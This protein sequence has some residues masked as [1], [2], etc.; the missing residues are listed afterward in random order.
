MLKKIVQAVVSLS[1][2]ALSEAEQKR[3]AER[4]VEAYRAEIDRHNWTVKPRDCPSGRTILASDPH[5]QINVLIAICAAHN[6]WELHSLQNSLYARALPWTEADLERLLTHIPQRIYNYYSDN[7][8]GAL[9]PVQRFVDQGN[10]LTPTLEKTLRAMQ[11]KLAQAHDAVP[12][13]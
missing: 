12:G 4:L 1:Q 7:W 11:Q 8:S 5:F 3:E 10:P 13:N 2:A 6:T 9:R